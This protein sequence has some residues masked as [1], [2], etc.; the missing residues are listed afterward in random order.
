MKMIFRNVCLLILLFMLAG[1]GPGQGNVIALFM[2]TPTPTNV[3]ATATPIPSATPTFTP[4]P[5]ATPVPPSATPTPVRVRT[6]PGEIICPILLYHRVDDLATSN[7]YVIGIQ[8]FR[9]QMQYL[10]DNG[11]QT[12]TVSELVAA[13]NFGADLPEKPVVITFDDGDLSVYKNAY[14]IMVEYGFTGVAYLVGNYIGTSGYM[15]VDQLKALAKSGWEMGSHTQGHADLSNCRFCD[16]EIVYSK[17]YLAEK[18]G[19]EINTFAFPFGIKTKK[20]METVI[21]NYKGAVGLGVFLNQG[22]YNLYYLWRRPIDNG[23][24]MGTFISYLPK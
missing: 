24:D 7:P 5:T 20:A 18:L 19:V 17:A 1:C 14:P 3:P 22:G 6:G 15:D 2:A 4:E 12:I 10:H 23:T 21:A 8:D 16:Q 11:Y 13:I 9:Q